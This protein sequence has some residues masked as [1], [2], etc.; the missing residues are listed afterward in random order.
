MNN[1]VKKITVMVLAGLVCL[2]ASVSADELDERLAAA[3]KQNLPVLLE[4][5]A[6]WC[7]PCQQMKPVIAKIE[8]AYRGRLSVIVIDV[9]RSR[10]QS[11]C[12]NVRFLPTLVFLDRN[13]K[14]YKR[15]FGG[16]SYE[17]IAAVLAS[18]GI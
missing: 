6:E 11:A 7:V 8:N 2:A 14:E 10:G 18:A 5:G 1:K 13:G 16:G 9:E 4:F 17:E 12:Y 3:K 15:L